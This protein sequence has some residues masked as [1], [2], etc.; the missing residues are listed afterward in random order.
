MLSAVR[1]MHGVDVAR[2]RDH[3]G[4]RMRKRKHATICLDNHLK[5]DNSDRESEKGETSW[6][7]SYQRG[8][9]AGHGNGTKVA[10]WK[11]INK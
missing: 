7:V 8:R 1:K 4:G 5:G 11:N 6:K 10:I 3:I 2:G 9:R